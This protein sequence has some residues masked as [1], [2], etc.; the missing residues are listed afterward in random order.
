MRYLLFC[1][2]FL[3]A[4][5]SAS[6]AAPGDPVFSVRY[7]FESPKPSG[8]F[9]ITPEKTL[10]LDGKTAEITIRNDKLQNPEKGISVLAVVKTSPMPG[11][12]DDDKSYDEIVYRHGQ[13][14]FGYNRKRLYANF[15]NGKKW[16]AP[17]H[18]KVNHSDGAFHAVA[19]TVQRTREI[20]QGLDY[21]EVKLYFDGTLLA[22]ERFHNV[23]VADSGNALNI[24]HADGFGDVWHWGGEIA[25]IYG[26]NRVLN[27]SEIENFAQE[28]PLIRE[29]ENGLSLSKDDRALIRSLPV[30]T[31]PLA[32]AASAIRNV[33]RR[34]DRF[35]WKEAAG[36]LLK[37]STLP[38]NLIQYKCGE[39]ILTVASAKD[40]AALV[41]L[42]D[43]ENRRELLR[44]K[45]PFF[46]LITGDKTLS[47]ADGEVRSAFERLDPAGETKR[48]RIVSGV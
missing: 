40:F 2:L 13:F 26:C 20:S 29:T 7:P 6:A 33:A 46:R 10:L 28:S 1:F 22:S 30:H 23:T 42:Y 16:C 39:M 35:N 36:H 43:C 12:S 18:A 27:L 31:A 15:H 17:L 38:E 32:A 25:E 3:F 11:N 14:T 19:M 4:L 45:N 47:P 44:P 37:K 9:R 34:T 8:N 24:G 5:F 48:F 21:L 41:S